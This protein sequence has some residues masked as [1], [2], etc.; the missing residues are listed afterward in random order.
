[1]TNRSLRT[2][3]TESLQTLQ[4]LRVMA[5]RSDV[6]YQGNVR[7]EGL[8]SRLRDLVRLGE[9][10]ISAK[11]SLAPAKYI[12][13]EIWRTITAAGFRIMGS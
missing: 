13:F 11:A 4:A 1:M 7:G 3:N 6:R 10:G 5:A 8:S 9:I 12:S 2:K